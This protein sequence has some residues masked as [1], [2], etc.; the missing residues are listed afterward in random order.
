MV[1]NSGNSTSHK[2]SVFWMYRSIYTG[3]MPTQMPM[4][5]YAG[6]KRCPRGSFPGLGAY[7]DASA[8][9]FVRWS[10]TK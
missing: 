8:G 1:Q 7:P 10:S 9:F 5:A 4:Y 3:S 2:S 6:W